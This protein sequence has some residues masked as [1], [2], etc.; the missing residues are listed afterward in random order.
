MSTIL[1]VS[2]IGLTIFYFILYHSIFRVMYFGNVGTSIVGEF[3]SCGFAACITLVFGA[4]AIKFI[5]GIVGGIIVFLLKAAVVL[6]I[7][8]GICFVIY[9]VV[10]AIKSKANDNYEEMSD[11][12]TD[13]EEFASTNESHTQN[14][15]EKNICTNCGVEYN[16]SAAF[17]V[18]CGEK[19]N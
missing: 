13:Q 16:E 19:I 5:F 17:C 1:L 8:G 15:G 18:N 14:D 3:I 4:A 10:N 12:N 11:I 6:A 7:V 9:C 2:I